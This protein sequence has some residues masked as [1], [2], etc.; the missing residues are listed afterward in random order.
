MGNQVTH[1]DKEA[2]KLYIKEPPQPTLTGPV[3][4]IS[5]DSRVVEGVRFFA[6]LEAENTQILVVGLA[7][8]PEEASAV[9]ETNYGYLIKHKPR[10]LKGPLG[11]LIPD[12]MDKHHSL[13]SQRM[14]YTVLC[15]WLLPANRRYRPNKSEIEWASQHLRD[16]IKRLKPEII[17]ACG[18][19]VFD[20]LSEIKISHADARGCWFEHE[21]IPLYLADP[22]VTLLTR[23][24]SISQFITDFREVARML[25]YRQGI[26]RELGISKMRM[27]TIETIDQLKALVSEWRDGNFKDFSV[28]CEWGGSNFLE[29]RLRSIQFAWTD[30][31]ACYL[32]FLDEHGTPVLGATPDGKE[33]DYRLCGEILNEWLDLPDTT[34][35]AHHASADT[36]WMERWLGLKVRGRVTFDSEFA[37]QTADEYAPLGLDDLALAMTA[38]GRYDQELVMWKRQNKLQQG[39]GYGKVPDEILIPYGQ[40]DVLTV[41]QAKPKILRS[42]ER[43]DLINYYRNFVNPFVTDVFHDWVVEG[44]PINRD[45]FERLRRFMNWCYERLL[46]DLITNLVKQA[47]ELMAQHVPEGAVSM[48][49]ELRDAGQKADALKLLQEAGDPPEALVAHWMEI[50]QMN[51]RS[52]PQMRVWLFDVMGLTPV[53]TT[54][55]G[56][57]GLPQMAWDAVLELPAAM[58]KLAVPATDKES[59]EIM[60]VQ[61]DSGMLLRCLAVSNVGNQCKGFLKE[62]EVG[63]DGEVVE[64]QGLAK[65]ICL[66]DHLHPNYSLAET[67]R[68][69]SWLPNVLN[70]SSYHN[71][72]V[73]RGLIRILENEK[74]PEEFL[75]LFNDEG[76]LPEGVTHKE[77]IKKYVPS[78]RSIVEAPEGQCFV[79]SDWKTAE[80]RDL[81]FRSGDPALIKLMTMPDVG[82]VM[83]QDG[84]DEV[85]VRYRWTVDSPV[86]DEQRKDQFL[87]AQWENGKLLKQFEESQIILEDG[88]PVH[89]PY[90][91]HW[92]LSEQ[93]NLA[94]REMLDEKIIRTGAK[95]TRF[96]IAEGEWVLTDQRGRVPIQE[97]ELTD[98]VWDGEN[99]VEHEGVIFNGLRE[100]IMHN[101]LIATPDHEVWIDSATK[102]TLGQASAEGLAIWRSYPEGWERTFWRSQ[103]RLIPNEGKWLPTYDIL[104]AGPNNRFLCSG[105]IVS[106]SATYGAVGKTIERRIEALT[107]IRP[108]PGTG[109]K[110]MQALADSQPIATQFLEDVSQMP[111]R[112]LQL[113]ANSGR[114]RRFPIHSSEL[115]GMPWRVRN[116][117]LRAMGNEARNFFMQESIG[118]TLMRA[119]IWMRGFE[120]RMQL[121]GRSLIG[122]Y[123]AALT[124][125][126]WEYRFIFKDVH[127]LFMQDVNCWSHH[128]R[129]MNFPIDTDLVMRWS[130]KPTKEQK[131]LLE[132]PEY[133]PLNKARDQQIRG[134]MERIHHNFL[135]CHPGMIDNLNKV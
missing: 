109:D 133:R 4:K 16:T 56:E 52:G 96:C 135:A 62:G 121:G 85:V 69:R 30:R 75:L 44:L 101:G 125:C 114:L 33:V 37:L 81:A 7:P 112:G 54:K 43:Q 116:S 108:E 98:R 12:C 19:I 24:W 77:L 29:G 21:K 131:L 55:G 26:D 122:L 11:T 134:E 74:L 20:V 39:D 103:F 6:P 15:P 60:S 9:T 86:A 22:V 70:L 10:L 88:N 92:M 132:D 65:F 117:Y 1:A 49:A 80:V 111:K 59:L 100:C 23:P 128:G 3:P 5:Q 106:N 14:S 68:T 84:N 87:L 41:F 124:R 119:M 2:D 107:G 93:V 64:E 130:F 82:F 79:E 13:Q 57:S 94:P 120:E 32:K 17:V 110:L 42:L 129:W 99:W 72:G 34:Y 83:V 66:D 35:M 115:Q 76:V 8:T 91:L 47:D 95:V 18:K 58:Q 27:R 71:A 51:I 46:A 61:D 104:N 48:A 127:K 50:R 63:P 118:A 73:A 113:R 78:V 38:F 25:D 97:V 126:E 36:P 123:D 40:L 28:D 31:D 105:V 90:D 67:S 53:K 102:M 45:R 89:P